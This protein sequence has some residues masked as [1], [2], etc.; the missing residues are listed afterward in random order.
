MSICLRRREFITLLGGLGI[1]A[2]NIRIIVGRG[3]AV[4]LQLVHPKIGEEGRGRTWED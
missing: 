3:E 4:V 1:S 2:S